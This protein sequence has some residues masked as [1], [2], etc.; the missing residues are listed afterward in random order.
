MFSVLMSIYKND[1]PDEFEDSFNSLLKQGSY[2]S[3]FVLVCDGPIGDALD[4]KVLDFISKAKSQKI[5]FDCIRLETNQGLGKALSIGQTYCSKDYV[6]RMDSDDISLQNRFVE[7]VNYI[8]K[9]PETDVIGAQIEEF[10]VVPGDL[11]NIRKV[12]LLHNDIF[13]YSKIRN[14]MNHVT[15]CIKKSSLENCGGYEDVLW[16]EDYY[17]WVKMLQKGFKFANLPNT[18]VAVRVKGIGD[19]RTGSKYFK[20]ELNFLNY[21]YSNYHFSLY[22]KTKYLLPRIFFRFMPSSLTGFMYRW[23]RS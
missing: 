5:M 20:A 18:H 19:R 10:S 8:K 13:K 12:P 2:I 9:Y 17:L 6:V 1:S 21:K 23:L 11:G 4:D 22:D 7:L 3:Q 15:V 16:H 14:P